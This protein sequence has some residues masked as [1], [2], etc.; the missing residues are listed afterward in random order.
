[1]LAAALQLARPLPPLAPDA[2]LPSTLQVAE[3]AR[4]LPWPEDGAAA[5]AVGDFGLALA[6][7][8]ARPRP[9]ASTARILTA[10]V[11]AN[12]HPLTPGEQGP[13]V[14]VTEADVAAYEAALTRDESVVAVAAGERLSEYQLLQ[15]LLLP[16]ANN[17]ADLLARWDAGSAEAFAAKL[18][19]RAAALGMAGTRLADAKGLSPAT[20][21][22]P[23]DLVRAARGAMAD[24]VLASIVARPQAELPL[25]G[26]VYNVNVA[27]GRDGI[28]GVKTGSTEA[29]G[30]CFAFAAK[31]QVAGRPV[32]VYGAVMGLSQ[33]SE[34]FEASRQL[35]VAARDALRPV[36]VLPRG[37]LVATFAVP[38]GGEP[39]VVAAEGVELL[40]W[41]GMTARA[42]AALDPIVTPLAEGARVGRLTVEAGEESRTVDLVTA[43]PL[44][45][46]DLAWRLTRARSPFG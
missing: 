39:Q 18:N 46:P 26:T 35:A 13:A 27:L 45:P 44:P 37:Q 36:E 6:H 1:V 41:P 12:D 33:L 42:T 34:A 38:W 40:G 25:A 22:A 16:S 20:V 23:E 2:L 11:V 29:A 14:T 4:Q 32:T 3:D 17:A 21:S 10:L 31:Y 5:L 7:G 15:S 8:D 43:D 19:A 30:A 24:P 9:M 28:V